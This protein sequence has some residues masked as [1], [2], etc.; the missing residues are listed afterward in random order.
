[1]LNKNNNKIPRKQK[2]QVIRNSSIYASWIL[3][4]SIKKCK[5]DVKKHK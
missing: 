4:S 3:A 1:M 2:G 5:A